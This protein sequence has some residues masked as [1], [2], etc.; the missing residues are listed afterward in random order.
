MEPSAYHKPITGSGS[1][2]VK[3]GLETTGDTPKFL[4]LAPTARI[5]T[6]RGPPDSI[7][8]PLIAEPPDANWQRF[9]TLMAPLPTCLGYN[10]N[11]VWA[12][13]TATIPV[14]LESPEF[15]A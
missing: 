11:A 1:Y 5:S 8:N 15:V 12:T 3:D 7:T 2:K 4:R 10:A 13:P 14:G 6:Q 9:D